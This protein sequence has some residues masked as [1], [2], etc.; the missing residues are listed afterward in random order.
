[1][2]R[3]GQMT[4][5]F[6]YNIAMDLVNQRMGN[7]EPVTPNDTVCVIF[8][9]AAKIYTGMSYVETYGDPANPTHAEVDALKGMHEYHETAIEAIM[10]VL[11]STR[12][13][14]LPCNSCLERIIAMDKSNAEA[15]I[16]V[17]DRLIRIDEVAKFAAP[18]V[19]V[20]VPPPPVQDYAS[21]MQG[22]APMIPPP[23]AS[24]GNNSAMIPELGNEMPYAT[25]RTYSN[26]T[27]RASGSLLKQRVNSLMSVADDDDDTVE[28]TKKGKGL[29]G[30]LFKR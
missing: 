13:L 28:E 18:Q 1:M 24:S 6:M 9:K 2:E 17:S 10:L 29:F 16:V 12:G 21:P 11:V 23:A 7:G 14:I 4:Y 25:E 22:N 30:G 15:S 8:T 20:N 3:S 5:E 19:Q 26:P 27:E